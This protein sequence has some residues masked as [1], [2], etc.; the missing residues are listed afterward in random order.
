MHIL[1][2]GDS[3]DERVDHNEDILE[4]RHVRGRVRRGRIENMESRRVGIGARR[5]DTSERRGHLIALAR[6]E[7]TRVVGVGLP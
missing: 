3:D 6:G 1:S 7:A 4:G 2:L 5:K